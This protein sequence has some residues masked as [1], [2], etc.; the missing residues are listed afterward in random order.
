MN[1]FMSARAIRVFP[2][3][4]EYIVIEKGKQ[5]DNNKVIQKII[6]QNLNC[7]SSNGFRGNRWHGWIRKKHPGQKVMHANIS[8]RKNVH[9]SNSP[10]K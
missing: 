7:G 9:N 8:T 10:F 1:S 2:N 5:D 4:I 3:A 6:V